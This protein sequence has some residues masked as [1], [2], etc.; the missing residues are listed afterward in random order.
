MEFSVIEAQSN[1]Y[2]T[3]NTPEEFKTVQCEQV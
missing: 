2:S 3:E 1:E